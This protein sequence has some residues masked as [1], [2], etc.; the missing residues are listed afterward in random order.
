MNAL[1]REQLTRF[2]QQLTQ[3]RPARKDSEADALIREAGDRQPDAAYLL[4]QRSMLLDQAVRNAQEEI[5]RLREE[6]EQARN[7]SQGA[8]RSADGNGS[9]L[10]ANAWGNSPTTRPA[11][12]P[13]PGHDPGAP[14]AAAAA[15]VSAPGA[16]GSGMLGNVATTAAGVVAGAF[17][18]QGIEHL[19]GASHGAHT[20]F[21]DGSNGHGEPS[22]STRHDGFLSDS[23]VDTNTNGN[24]F[25]TSSVDDFIADDS[26]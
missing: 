17:L 23:P 19:I 1:E 9:F 3:A 4:V 16:W 21:L 11:P 25:D 14:A 20:G 6:L 13:R 24:I 7:P 22:A 2:L 18:F 8:S 5:S 15:P 12:P 26:V 10:D